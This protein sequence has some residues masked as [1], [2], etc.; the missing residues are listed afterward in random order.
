MLRIVIDNQEIEILNEFDLG[1]SIDKRALD[2]SDPFARLGSRSYTITLPATDTNNEIFSHGNHEQTTNKFRD[3]TAVC[4]DG[5]T[6]LLAGTF[7]LREI[8]RTT[9]KGFIFSN[10]IGF[11][12]IIEGKSLQE[13]DLGSIRFTALKN[14]DEIN[15]ITLSDTWDATTF[16]YFQTMWFAL[17][18]YGNFFSLDQRDRFAKIDE[19]TFTDFTPNYQFKQI[20]RQIFEEAGYSVSGEIVDSANFEDL[21]LTYTGDVVPWNW[22]LLTKVIIDNVQ[23]FNTNLPMLGVSGTSPN[24]LIANKRRYFLQNVNE[25]KDHLSKYDNSNV[26]PT[27]FP[28]GQEW[29]CPREGLY[30]FTFNLQTVQTVTGDGLDDANAL[31]QAKHNKIVLL[32]ADNG[33]F[34]DETSELFTRTTTPYASTASPA[35]DVNYEKTTDVTLQVG[36]SQV[37]KYDSALGGTLDGQYNHATGEYTALTD[38]T[39]ELGLVIDNADPFL[40]IECFVNGVKANIVPQNYIVNNDYVVQIQPNDPPAPNFTNY[41]AVRPPFTFNYIGFDAS[42]FQLQAGD[43]VT[44]TLTNNGN[45]PITTTAGQFRDLLLSVGNAVDRPVPIFEINDLVKAYIEPW[46]SNSE[47]EEEKTGGAVSSEYERI[48]VSY[49]NSGFSGSAGNYTYTTD[50]QY[51]FRVKCE[52]GEVIKLALLTYNDNAN[53]SYN[54]D[55]T[56]EFTWAIVD[57][58]GEEFVLANA[59][60]D[61]SQKDFITDVVRTFNLYPIVDELTKT[62]SLV[63]RSD[64]FN[65]SNPIELDYS[66]RN[67]VFEPSG[68]PRTLRLGFLQVEDDYSDEL[69]GVREVVANP[70]APKD[71]TVTYTSRYIRLAYPRKY[72]IQGDPIDS[73]Q[74]EIPSVSID[75]S[76]DVLRAEVTEWKTNAQ[77]RLVKRGLNGQYLLALQSL[78]VEG[79]LIDEILSN[80]L[81]LSVVDNFVS[82]SDGSTIFGEYW[83]DIFLYQSTENITLVVSMTAEDFNKIDLRRGVLINNNTYTVQGVYGFNP[84]NPSN[85]KLKLT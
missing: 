19:L 3:Y 79:V 55:I 64:Y 82:F 34:L 50:I 78:N 23:T 59:L 20:V 9:Y 10:D 4:Y 35:G 2:V 28:V 62:V 67:R 31:E 39:I 74:F 15:G 73:K 1:L 80:V 8:T 17:I 12:D 22:E 68:S 60:P 6:Q 48:S 29:F 47:T 25:T 84:L 75:G 7:R 40:L 63:K 18:S 43:V 72:V 26:N 70:N 77:M 49:Q 45:A 30:E 83:N 46:K 14:D 11:A 36:E 61:I 38:Q 85:V 65:R 44:F 81:P 76:K 56:Q 32:N 66:F 41:F 54:L 16:E 13:L 42:P 33:D 71:N 24:P 5:E 52:R 57:G 69:E 37:I 27:S 53:Y 21:M 58:S 51:T